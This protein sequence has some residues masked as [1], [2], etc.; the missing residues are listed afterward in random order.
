MNTNNTKQYDNSNIKA[1]YCNN[2]Q[3][4]LD[5][6]NKW[7]DDINK[8]I[9]ELKCNNNKDLSTS[10][11]TSNSSTSSSNS[12]K[13]EDIISSCSTVDNDHIYLDKNGY[14]FKISIYGDKTISF[15][16]VNDNQFEHQTILANDEQL[17]DEQ[18]HDVLKILKDNNDNFLSRLR[19]KNKIKK[20]LNNRLRDMSI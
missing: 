12:V 9:G 19:V 14:G 4:F 2:I 20:L 3:S 6:Q 5:N 16:R 18:L 17:T 7:F 1:Q 8:A 15:I 10:N 11:S 13:S